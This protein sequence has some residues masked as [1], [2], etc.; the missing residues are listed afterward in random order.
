MNSGTELL[1]SRCTTALIIA[2]FFLPPLLA[3]CGST[4]KTDAGPTP[5][6]NVVIKDVN[7]YTATSTLTIPKVQT[8]P[9]ADLKICWDGIANDLL[10]H[11][12]SPASDINSVTFLQLTNFGEAKMQ[13]ALGTGQDFTRNVANAGTHTVAAGESCA[14][15]STFNLYGGKGTIVPATNYVA[16]SNYTYMLLFSKGTTIGIGAKSMLFLEPTDGSPTTVNGQPGCGILDFTPDITT[17]TPLGVLLSPPWVLDWSLLTTDGLG[18]DVVFAN[19]D[20]L[21]VGYY[22]G[23][24]V[25][26]V[27]ARFLDLEIMA[28][29][30]Y[31][32]AIPKGQT[33]VDLTTAT[34]PSGAFTGFS[35]AKGVWAAALLCSTCQVPAPVALTILNPS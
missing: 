31:T 7:N 30:T 15:L 33:H 19:I 13:I 18:N 21:M 10:C 4:N 17:P 3:A 1:K 29:S 28:T 23:M 6:G 12:L 2:S 26:Q 5:V 20:S 35:P 22:D 32:V 25:A 11:A 16:G 24:T 27:Q 8:T 14:N 34:G 9:G